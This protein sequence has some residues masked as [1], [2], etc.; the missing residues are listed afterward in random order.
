MGRLAGRTL[1]ESK[2][3]ADYDLT[4]IAL[5]RSNRTIKPVERYTLIQ[6][7]DILMVE[8]SV[9][10]LMRARDDLGL[11][12]ANESKRLVDIETIESGEDGSRGSY[13]GAALLHGE[14]QP[15]FPEFP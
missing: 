15:A 11:M 7:D 10:N 4:V 6:S 12:T 3:G 2:L 8:G 14:P 1:L 13:P 5:V 9:E